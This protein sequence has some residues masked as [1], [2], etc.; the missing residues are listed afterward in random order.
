MGLHRLAARYYAGAAAIAASPAYKRAEEEHK[1]ALAWCRAAGAPTPPFK[2]TGLGVH[3]ETGGRYCGNLYASG[4][5]RVRFFWSTQRNAAGYFMSWRE[6]QHN[7]K[8]THYT[9]SEMVAYKSRKACRERSQRM[10]AAY[11]ERMKIAA[12]KKAAR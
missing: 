1:V 10:H 3:A 6:T 2:F 11:V 9:V 7:A 8:G 4:S 5:R 12:R